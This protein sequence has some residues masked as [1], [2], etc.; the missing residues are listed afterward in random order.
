M[1]VAQPWFDKL[2]YKF[3][4]LYTECIQTITCFYSLYTDQQCPVISNKIDEE[5]DHFLVFKGS[6]GPVSPGAEITL[7][8]L[9][10]VW[11]SSEDSPVAFLR[12]TT[13]KSV[14]GQ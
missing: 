1:V 13:Q 4:H 10:D 9:W 5:K 3:S 12:Q 14:N 7:Y 6:V 2:S 11:F 8:D